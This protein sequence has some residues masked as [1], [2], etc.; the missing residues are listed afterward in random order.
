MPK[1]SLGHDPGLVR[2]LRSMT[3][4]LPDMLLG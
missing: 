1:T 2:L 3:M 4:L